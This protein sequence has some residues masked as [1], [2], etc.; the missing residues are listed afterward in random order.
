MVS[1]EKLQYKR[2]YFDFSTMK[3]RT[4]ITTTITNDGT[5]VSKKYKA[6]S[7]KVN[8]I[9]K[10][11]CSLEEF[12]ELCNKIELCIENADRLD[13][14]VDDASEELRIFYKYGR[15]QTMDRGLGNDNFDIGKIV[16]SFLTKHL[17]H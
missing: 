14:Y 3:N 9:Q 4:S 15:I 7:R 5:I 10:T 17:N 8:S 16:N 12:Q 13:F 11:I 6:G 2:R 1:I